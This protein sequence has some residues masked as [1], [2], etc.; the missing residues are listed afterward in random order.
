MMDKLGDWIQEEWWS[1]VGKNY[2]SSFYKVIRNL[3]LGFYALS[4]NFSSN[5]VFERF[6][7]KSAKT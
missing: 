1:V 5:F 2:E 6:F 4:Q 3:M 7:G